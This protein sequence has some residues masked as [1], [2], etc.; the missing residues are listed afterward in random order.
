MIYLIVAIGSLVVA[1]IVAKVVDFWGKSR[2]GGE[3]QSQDFYVDLEDEALKDKIYQQVAGVVDSK[4]K[5]R[6]VSKA[7]Y[8]V[9]SKELQEKLAKA[10]GE[11]EQKYQKIID[12]KSKTEEIVLKKYKKVLAEKKSTEAIVK[13]IAEGLVVVDSQGKVIMLNPAAEKLLGV[14]KKDKLGKSLLEGVKK[15]QLVSLV[16]GVP[17]KEE[18]EIELVSQDDETKKILRASTAV[19]ENEKGQTVGMVSVLSDITKQKELDQLKSQFIANVSHELR[20]P[21]V[22]IDKSISLLLSKAVGSLSKEQEEFLSIARRNLKR[23]TNLINDLL[24]MSKLEAKRMA[25]NKRLSSIEE[26][27]REAVSSFQHWADT[28]SIKL[29]QEVREGL[30]QVN[31]DPDRVLQVL[32]N[33]L[34]NALKFTP[35]GGEVKVSSFLEEDALKV[36]VQD[37]GAGIPQ[38]DLPRV[39]DKFYQASFRTS[40]VTGT[41]LGLSIAKEIIELHGGKIWVESQEGKGAKFIFIL[42]IEKS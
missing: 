5:G 27:V 38:K 25:L 15:E 12:E 26:V 39:F 23:L 11:L 20:T 1:F 28:K 24:D 36:I 7:I 34:S 32:N 30:P 8:S 18:K 16:K 3:R 6:E 40:E 42:P 10:R 29:I 14:D 21:L 37:T 17:D 13:S 33:L 9:V 31:I 2:E 4:Y 41:G 35:E 19:I 22:A